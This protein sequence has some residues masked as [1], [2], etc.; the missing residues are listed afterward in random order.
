MDP[1][2]GTGSLSSPFQGFSDQIRTTTAEATTAISGFTIF[3]IG[4]LAGIALLRA[5]SK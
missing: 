1:T 4:A 3:I 2:V 5:L